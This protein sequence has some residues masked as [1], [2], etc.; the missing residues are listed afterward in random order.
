MQK[1]A[2]SNALRRIVSSMEA[3]SIWIMSFFPSNGFRCLLLRLWGSNIGKGVALH[4]GLQVRCAR[5]LSIGNDC[6]IAEDV[7][8]DARGTLSIGDS[9]SVNSGVQIWTAQHDWRSP[10]FEYTTGPVK[11]A[12]HSWISARVVV[13]P[14]KIIGEGAV[15]A[16]GAVVTK[17]IPAWS[18]AGGNP[19]RVLATRPVVNSYKLD[20]SRSKLLWW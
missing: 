13:I 11:I 2:V 15:L 12:S 5:R 1:V 18:L 3:N 6:Y 9:V 4:H 20:A 10:N 14:G 19:A 8:L 7:V 17:D 16:A